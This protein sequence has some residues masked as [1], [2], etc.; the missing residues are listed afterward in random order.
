MPR[1][2]PPA[3]STVGADILLARHGALIRAW[4]YSRRGTHTRVRLRGGGWD[5]APNSLAVAPAEGEGGALS[6]RRLVHRRPPR[7][8][9]RG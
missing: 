8:A 6:R 1:L 5:E 3:S 4:R 2:R 7:E 9:R